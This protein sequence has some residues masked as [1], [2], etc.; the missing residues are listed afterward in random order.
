VLADPRPRMLRS[1]EKQICAPQFGEIKSR[2]AEIDMGDTRNRLSVSAPVRRLKLQEIQ[3][4]MLQ[5]HRCAEKDVAPPVT[6]CAISHDDH[7]RVFRCRNWT[8]AVNAAGGSLLGRA[9]PLPKFTPSS[10]RFKSDR[11][12]IT[13]SADP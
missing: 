5:E 12:A 8:F 2:M 3:Q 10:K 11:P 1:L 4:A 13:A 9:P 6:A 7:P